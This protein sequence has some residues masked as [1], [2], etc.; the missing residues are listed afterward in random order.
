MTGSLPTAL[1]YAQEHSDR[2]LE[3]LK[4]FVR[5]PSISTD[6][7]AKADVQRA[8]QW[9]AEQLKDLG[10]HNVNIFPTAR[11]PVVYGELLTAGPE[12]PTILIY[13]YVKHSR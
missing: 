10:M 4:A 12:K 3:E 13:I 1:A 11:H 7:S 6:P 5:I 9:V 2:F 8:A